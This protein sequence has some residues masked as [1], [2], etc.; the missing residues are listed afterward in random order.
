MCFEFSLFHP[1]STVIYSPVACFGEHAEDSSL[2][3]PG[4]RLGECVLSHQ[5]VWGEGIEA[6]LSGY[7]VE[8]SFNNGVANHLLSVKIPEDKWNGKCAIRLK[9]TVGTHSWKCDPDPVI[10]LGKH[11]ISPE[12]FGFLLPVGG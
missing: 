4:L 9:I 3:D 8:S 6:E 12:D 2:H 5:S 1:E 10:T 7:R 11:D